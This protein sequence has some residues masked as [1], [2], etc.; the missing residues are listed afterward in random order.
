MILKILGF[1]L[2][3]RQSPY[4]RGYEYA[5]VKLILSQ[6]SDEPELEAQSLG[7]FNQKDSEHDFDRGIRDAIRDYGERQNAN[8]A[9]MIEQARR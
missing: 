5:Q 6:G 8:V 1:L 7:T 4:Q 3:K 9:N 2:R